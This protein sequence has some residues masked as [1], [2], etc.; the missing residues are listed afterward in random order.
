MTIA[1]SPSPMAIDPV[2]PRAATGHARPRSAFDGVSMTFPDGTQAVATTSLRRGAR[3]SSSRSSARR[4]RQVDAAAHRL[5]PRRARATGTVDVDRNDLGYV[6]QDATL[7]PWRTVQAQRRAARR[8]ARHATRP[9]ARGRRTDAIEL[10]GLTGFENKYPKQLSGG[11]KMR[12]SLAR[13]LVL[14]PKVFL[15]DE[16]FGALDEITRE[17]LNDELLALFQ[18]RGLRRA[19]HHPLDLRG[20]VPVDPGA[21]DVGPAGPDR[22]RVRRPVP[23]PAARP[24]CASSRSSPSCRGEVSHALRGAHAMTAESPCRARR[25]RR[26]ATYRAG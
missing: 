8:A 1:A 16:P 11:M 5:R 23:V 4:L 24:S 7:L 22:R 20:G 13:S 14:E 26:P 15:F 9:S 6:F 25:R 3:A 12:A 18:Q 10:V 19:V 21:G 2:R 17:R